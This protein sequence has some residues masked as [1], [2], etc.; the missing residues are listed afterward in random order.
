MEQLVQ[1][2]SDAKG[3][4]DFVTADAIR[5]RLTNEFN[6]VVDD[7][8]KLWS[9]GGDFGRLDRNRPFTMSALSEPVNDE[10]KAMIEEMIEQ[11]VTA[12]KDRDFD[13]ADDIRDTLVHEF[14]V[15]VEDRLREWSVGG[16]FSESKRVEP[17]AQAANSDEIHN[18]VSIMLQ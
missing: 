14:G 5:D 9:V 2:R 10:D 12:K 17:Y 15:K 18:D 16:M 11:R 8:E 6:V 13:V 3:I 4:R 1:E 7:R